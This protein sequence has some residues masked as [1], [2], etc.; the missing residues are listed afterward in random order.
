MS[1]NYYELLGLTASASQDEI[2]RA[3][4]RLALQHNPNSAYQSA[5]ADP[6]VFEELSKAFS[7]LS[8]TQKR[9]EYDYIHGFFKTAIDL[10]GDYGSW[11]QE[12]KSQEGS[13]RGRSFKTA[14]IFGD[15][16]AETMLDSQARSS[17]MLRSSQ[18]AKQTLASPNP[19][20]FSDP[21]RPLSWFEVLKFNLR[22][23][24]SRLGLCEALPPAPIDNSASTPY[25]ELMCVTKELAFQIDALESL[26]G[27]VRQAELPPDES[28]RP[29][30]VRV[31]IPAGVKDGATL[32]VRPTGWSGK[33]GEVLMATV[34]IKP[35]AI[36]ER[37]GYDV[38]VKLPISIGEA[39]L[40][41][42]VEVPTLEGTVRVKIPPLDSHMKKLRLKGL[43]VKDKKKD[44]QGDL[45]VQ[46]YIVP[47][48][49]VTDSVREAAKAIE[50]HYMTPVRK[51]IPKTLA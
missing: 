51:D 50:S 43:G 20:R 9:N 6:A 15:D 28:G 19:A 10:T 40:G 25:E 4:Q 41:T 27:T 45:F 47:P 21:T 37:D 46:P 24:G 33:P 30:I 32:K 16:S 34:E 48:D 13:Q 5:D 2:K 8:D 26:R 11:D 36:V 12:D 17:K 42:E 14:E 49:T 23:L 29:R 31:M 1:K 3:Y 39:I 35:H 22:Q 18:E 44:I 38:I 7:I